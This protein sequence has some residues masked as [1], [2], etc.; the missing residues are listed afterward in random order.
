MTKRCRPSPIAVSSITA[1][2]P[3]AMPSAVSAVRR[4]CALSEAVLKRTKSAR[5][6]AAA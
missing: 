1:A 3:T 2:M 4:R 5:R 6:I